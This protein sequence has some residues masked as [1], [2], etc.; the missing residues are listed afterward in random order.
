MIL[1]QQGG[2]TEGMQRGGGAGNND[3]G[4][5]MVYQAQTAEV[6]IRG[7]TQEQ[8]GIRVDMTGRCAEYSGV[9]VS[10]VQDC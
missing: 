10:P 2:N 6:M 4:F 9:R 1:G 7:A 8:T 3:R 5:V